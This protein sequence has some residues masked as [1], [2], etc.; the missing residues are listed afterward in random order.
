YAAIDP[1]DLPL[2]ESLKDTI[3]RL[4]PYWN[5]T[6]FPTLKECDDVIVTAHGNSLRSIIKELKGISDK[7]IISLNLPTAI[8]YVFEFDDNLKLQKDFFLGDPE[9]IKKLMDAVANQAKGV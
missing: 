2:T 8:P 5:E 9:V 3:H 7:D 6:I 4:L 1:K